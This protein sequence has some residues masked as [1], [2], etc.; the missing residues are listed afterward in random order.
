MNKSEFE[1]ATHGIPKNSVKRACY[2]VREYMRNEKLGIENYCAVT[3]EEYDEA[4]SILLTFSYL[5]SENDTFVEQ[6]KCEGD[7]TKNNGFCG[8]CQG[9]FQL[10]NKKEK[11]L[12]KYY[13][14]PSNI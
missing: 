11:K 9:E 14:D 10:G 2:I 1:Y 5:N 12:C 13:S 8:F 7:C 6:F 3:K 4:V